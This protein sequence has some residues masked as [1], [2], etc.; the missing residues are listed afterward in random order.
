MDR[1]RWDRYRHRCNVDIEI[2][3]CWL[4]TQIAHYPLTNWDAQSSNCHRTTLHRG[5]ADIPRYCWSVHF[6]KSYVKYQW[7]FQEPPLELPRCQNKPQDVVQRN[8]LTYL[9]HLGSWLPSPSARTTSGLSSDGRTWRNLWT[10]GRS[11]SRATPTTPSSQWLVMEKANRKM[12]DD[13][14]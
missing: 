11:I 10:N 2:Y 14:G 13:W 9:A 1:Q 6:T 3:R 7:S 4:Y 8:A 12:E 5:I